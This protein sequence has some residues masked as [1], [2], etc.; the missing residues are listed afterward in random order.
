MTSQLQGRA[1]YI[2]RFTVVSE[3][4]VF[5]T[6]THLHPYLMGINDNRTRLSIKAEVIKMLM[7]CETPELF[8]LRLHSKDSF[9]TSF[10]NL[11]QAN[12]LSK[13]YI[14]EFHSKARLLTSF[15]NNRK[16]VKGL[17]VTYNLINIGAL[18]NTGV[19]RFMVQGASELVCSSL[20]H[21]SRIV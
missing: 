16:G 13:W 2:K 15:T 17:K 7:M 20:L 11:K 8:Q 10:T 18:I 4:S 19:K 3:P 12:G 21:T 14:L 5:V 1:C 6:A 9:L